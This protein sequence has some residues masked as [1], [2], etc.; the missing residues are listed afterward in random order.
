VQGDGAPERV[1]RQVVDE[2]PPALDLDHG[3]PLAMLALERRVA[4]DVD[5]LELEAELSLQAGELLAGPLA[6]MAT[7][8][9]VDGDA[10][11]G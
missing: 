11:Y 7:L 3:Q 4:G 5:L 1:L 9:V 6:E 8:R 2:P 10:S